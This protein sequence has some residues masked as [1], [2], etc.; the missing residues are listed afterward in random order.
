MNRFLLYLGM[1]VLLQTGDAYAEV[2]YILPSAKSGFPGQEVNIHFSG[3]INQGKIVD[4]QSAIDKFNIEEPTA[5]VINLYINSSGGDMD[6]GWSGYLAIKSSRIPTRTIDVAKTD[7]AA[8]LL[9]CASTQRYVMDGATFLLHPA[10]ISS[11]PS[12]DAKPDE[13]NR[14]KMYLDNLNK[15][16]LR[17]YRECTHLNESKIHQILSAEYFSKIVD[18]AE[19][20]RIGLAKKIL[21]VEYPPGASAYIY[22]WPGSAPHPT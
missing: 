10:A 4:L 16:F 22:D 8:T 2:R 19:A 18:D 17:V 21:S 3:A 1:L 5:K 7:S 11:S 13:V 12:Q 14:K 6:S 9:Y 15:Y 20:I